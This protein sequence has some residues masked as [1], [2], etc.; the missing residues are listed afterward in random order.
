VSPPAGRRDPEPAALLDVW[1]R[2]GP[3]STGRRALALLATTG[4]D[5]LERLSIGERDAD[6]LSLRERLFGPD[7]TA[8][9]ACP[10]CGERQELSFRVDD[11]RAPRPDPA[12]ALSVTVDG[13]EVRFRMPTTADLDLLDGD[14][15]D[16]E[17]AAIALL[18]RCVLSGPGDVPPSAAVVAA[19]EERMAAADPQADVQLG[20]CCDGCGSVWDAPFDIAAFLWSELDAWAWRLVADVDRLARTYGWTERD[21]LALS[22]QRRRIYLEVAAR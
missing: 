13:V 18:Q 5:G 17:T 7:V 4:A 12:P 10:A 9:V 21:V 22:P 19:V 14:G 16:V 1:E 2:G 15:G 3:L 11:V 6:L 8:V 20:L